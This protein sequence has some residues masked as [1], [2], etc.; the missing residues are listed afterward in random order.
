M[1]MYSGL[2]SLH[3]CAMLRL[4]YRLCFFFF[5]SR[6]RHTRCALVTGVQT[7]ALPI[8][9]VLRADTQAP[10]KSAPATDKAAATKPEPPKAAA[11]GTSKATKSTKAAADRKSVV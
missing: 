2:L 4:D 8:S 10:E 7:C 3:F 1:R 6:R 11:K 5:S 9:E